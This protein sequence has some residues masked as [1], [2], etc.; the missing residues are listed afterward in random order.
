MDTWL[1]LRSG[2][3]P[4]AASPQPRRSRTGGTARP[5]AVL[6]MLSPAAI[7]VALGEG[8]APDAINGVVVTFFGYPSVNVRFG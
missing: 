6:L 4:A 1:R 7:A 5:W 2:G 3:R 8:W